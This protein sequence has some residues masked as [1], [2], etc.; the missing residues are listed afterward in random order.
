MTRVLFR[1]DA[2][3]KIG[4]GHLSRCI[5][6]AEMLKHDF[7]VCFIL[8]K[9][10]R[11]FVE[12]QLG[13][14]TVKYLENEGEL[15]GLVTER[16]ILCVDGYSFD[17]D[18][19]G[20]IKPYVYKL[21]I[22]DDL[23]EPLKFVDVI[24]NY[25]PGINRKLYTGTDATHLL[26]GLKYVLLRPHFL[27]YARQQVEQ[28]RHKNGVFVCFGGADPMNLGQLFVEQLLKEGFEDNIILVTNK[29]LSRVTGEDVQNLSIVSGLSE[30]EMIHYIKSVRVAVVSASVLSFE[31]AALRVPS[32]CFY[33]VD[34]QRLIYKGLIEEKAI[35][36]GGLVKNQEDVK[37]SINSFMEFYDN[38]FLQNRIIAKQKELI[39]GESGERLREFMNQL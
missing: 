11:E 25:A 13:D 26:T 18:W 16:D 20:W 12:G 24:V 23:P 39:D 19:R 2:N 32:F 4:R 29:P 30:N 28:M 35:C 3:D 17:V 37:R 21:I 7:Q 5:A 15:K 8:L 1:V 14:Y 22:I 33:Y 36:G 38:P 34:N 10:S 9:S 31:V 27:E 6:A